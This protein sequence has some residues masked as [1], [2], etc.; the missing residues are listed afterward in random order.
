MVE[1]A[2]KPRRYSMVAIYSATH[3]VVDFACAFLMFRTILNT[4]DWHICVLIY[5]FCAFAMQM[6]IG[7]LADRLNRNCVFAIIGCIFTAA[8]YGISYFPIAA[9]IVAGVGNGMF[10][11][12]GGIDVLNISESKAGMLGVF[13]SPGAFGIYFGTMLGRG[14]GRL[15]VIVVLTLVVAAALILTVR[16]KQGAMYVSNAT[17][18]LD[19]GTS[20]S[21]KAKALIA[22][23]CFFIVVCLRSYAGLA[24]N[25]AW[26]GTRYWGVL[27][28]FAVVIGKT[29]GGFA[30]DRFGTVRVSIISLTLS[31]L[32]FLASSFP[33]AG[34][35]A[36]FLFNMTMPITLWAVAKVFPGAKGFSFGFLTFGLFLGFLPVYMGAYPPPGSSRL[37]VAV[38]V[39]SFLLLPLG[40]K[41][42]DL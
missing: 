34:I 20:T 13:V 27:L 15:G 12:G 37:F 14:T 33:I 7:I 24:F 29:A 4:P 8:A 1:C 11:I 18:S 19:G 40:L 28:V 6:P 9:A 23:A 35:A 22:V 38:A 42:A 2:W 30:S 31:A 26:K 5:N 16:R 21:N 3:F 17:F 39:A 25:F 41:K 36:M 10:H 32:L